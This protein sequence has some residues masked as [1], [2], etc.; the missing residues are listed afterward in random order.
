MMR[1]VGFRDA[2]SRIL[3]SVSALEAEV[4]EVSEACGRVLAQDVHAPIDIP[5]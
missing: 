1:Q 5:P 2:L 4:V 3:G